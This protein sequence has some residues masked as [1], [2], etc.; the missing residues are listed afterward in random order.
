M[1]DLSEVQVIRA[2]TFIDE[3]LTYQQ[4]AE[5]LDVSKSVVFRNVKRF[6]Q[7][8]KQVPGI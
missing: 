4:V 2:V 6:Q 8:Y 5:R 1:S 3:G 7:V